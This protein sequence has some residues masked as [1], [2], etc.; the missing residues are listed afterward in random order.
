MLDEGRPEE[1]VVRYLAWWTLIDEEEAQRALPSLRRPFTE[2][3]IFCYH[4]GR[5][6]LEAGMRGPDRNVFLRRLLTQQ[7]CPTDLRAHS[8]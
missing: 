6:L 5:E 8:A 4:H 3:Y 2:A 7:I 1:E